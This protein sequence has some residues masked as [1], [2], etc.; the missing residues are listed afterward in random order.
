M[1]TYRGGCHCRKVRF[2]I[3]TDLTAVNQ[4]NC[5]ICQKKGA[6]HH[7]VSQEQFKLLSGEGDLRLYQFNTKTA[8]HYFCQ[9]CGIHPFSMPRTAPDMYSIN[10]NCLDEA[11]ILLQKAEVNKFDGQNWEESFEK[12]KLEKDK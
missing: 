9:H 12:L 4:C 10:I 8:K 3:Q 7:K 11:G 2:E 5:T 1:K 6:L